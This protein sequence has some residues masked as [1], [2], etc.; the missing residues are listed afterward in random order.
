MSEF[1][2]IEFEFLNDEQKEIIIALLSEMSF[3][4]FEEEGDLLK[5][6]ISSNL[7]DENVLRNLTDALGLSCSVTKVESENWNH[8]WESNFQP[9]VINHPSSKK[10]WIAVRAEFHPPN[11]IVEHEVI[12]TPKMSF[13]TGHHATTLMMIQMMAQLDFEGKSVLDFGTGTGV[14]AIVAE[15]LGASKIMAIDND[16]QSIKNAAENFVS[17]DCHGIELRQASSA[18][19]INRYDVILS[20]IIKNVILAN[21]FSFAAQLSDNGVLLL[22]GMLQEDEQGI[23]KSAE[24][25]QLTLNKKIVTEQWLC[26]KMSRVNNKF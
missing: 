7:Y 1:L 26:L 9:V 20:N 10:P 15:K 4:G 14:L 24:K 12:I 22:S 3:E 11:K 8:V 21:L 25:N 19:G 6:Y 16:P 17:N 18:E 13:G 23:V 5:A 2:Q